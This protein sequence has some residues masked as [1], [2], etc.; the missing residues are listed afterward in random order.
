MIHIKKKK[1]L[2]KKKSVHWDKEMSGERMI[3]PVVPFLL[4]TVI[5]GLQYADTLFI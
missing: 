3:R 2:K 1:N 5:K 4:L